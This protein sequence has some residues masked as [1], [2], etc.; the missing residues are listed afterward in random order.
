MKIDFKTAIL[1]IVVCP[2][3]FFLLRK[4]TKFF[5]TNLGKVLD[6]I[7]WAFGSIFQR[8]MAR[9]IDLKRYCEV[10]LRKATFRYLK[11]P[12]K[13]RVSLETDK[14]FVP[15]TFEAD[16]G[17][18][19][20]I[21]SIKKLGNRLRIVGDP[22]SGKTSL[23]KKMFRMA[24]V[25]AISRSADEH[26]L[27]IAV[28]LKSFIPPK[29]L[30]SKVALGKW[31]LARLK[32]QVTEVHGFSMAELF[33]SYS[34]GAGLVVFLDGLD[35]VASD[36]YDRTAKAINGLSELLANQSP[37]N[38]IFLTMRVQF[39]QQVHAHL[40]DEFPPVVQIK[41]FAP[42]DIYTFLTR[43]PFPDNAGT[44][45]TRIFGDLTDRPTVREMCTNPLVLAMYVA[46]DQSSDTGS[47]SADTRTAFYS[48][49][50]EELL[51]TRRSRQLGVTARSALLEQRE[52]IL[53]QLALEN[54]SNPDNAANVVSWDRAID[55]V[56]ATYHGDKET[57]I[58]RFREIER[59][60]GIISEE[61]PEESLRF[62]HLT[63]CE[64]L[65]AKEYAQ[66]RKDGWTELIV[67]HRKF[68]RSDLPQ[69]KTRLVEVI[70]FTLGLL[71]RS[72]RAEALNDVVSLRDQLILGRC[73]LE[74]QLYDHD[75]WEVY[76]KTEAKY[77]VDITHGEADQAGSEWL[78]RLHLFNV[79]LS[80]QAQWAAV[81]V[82]PVAASLA[83]VFKEIVQADRERLATVFSS[84]ASRD[85]AAAF[86]LAEATGFDLITDQRWLVVDNLAN[87]PFLDIAI[88]RAQRQ[89]DHVVDW[90][91]AFAE[92]SLRNVIVAVRLSRETLGPV[93]SSSLQDVDSRF[94]WHRFP[95][96]IYS[97]SSGS[98]I[99]NSRLAYGLLTKGRIN[100]KVRLLD[101]S[102]LTA[103]LT[104]ATKEVAE[105][106][107]DRIPGGLA[108]LNVIKPYGRLVP[109][110][111][112]RTLS[113]FP[114]LTI[115]CLD[116]LM[117]TP[118]GK[119]PD[120]LPLSVFLLTSICLAYIGI[121]VY[122]YPRQRIS[123]YWKVVGSF[124]PPNL[125]RNTVRA[126]LTGG[127][128]LAWLVFRKADRMVEGQ[129]MK[130]AFVDT[131]RL[132][133]TEQLPR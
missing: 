85:P 63:F 76:W 113:I 117:F 108:L 71:P 81:Y 33:D 82:R 77:L 96:A 64:Y 133:R 29:N 6:A 1:T 28:E 30:T 52:S 114:F 129:Q 31:A 83:E 86:R 38:Q 79:V 45:I 99:L 70:P 34:T 4:L 111:V 66:G 60:T 121:S 55:V 124:I 43:W 2:V 88:E 15:L 20:S 3:L 19:R 61:R 65:A 103:A 75:S 112:I 9:H 5:K 84:Y 126:F 98:L 53:G 130:Q 95:L 106:S 132:P 18:P 37:E 105:R 54:L 13:S 47:G 92:A 21:A 119:T 120:S 14:I 17:E 67:N 50:V 87:P 51:V 23:V 59:D 100:P 115:F 110:W 62:I 89:A 128:G 48:R 101:A 118:G 109:A 69:L 7:L 123:F 131:R 58:A 49:V 90:A 10:Q 102:L 11:V 122:S 104:L 24:C 44:N 16:T 78:N 97:N 72:E 8:S 57:A 35:E 40:D 41:P 94:S 73:L 107:A 80:D 12:G 36:A 26:H 22:G 39:H 42:A 127:R 46:N 27:P 56:M 25:E 68:A 32:G 116:I 91:L 74:T 125:R 93:I